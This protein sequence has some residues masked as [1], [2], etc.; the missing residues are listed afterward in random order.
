M[1]ASS[2]AERTNT[3]A[4]GQ[5]AERETAIF[6]LIEKKSLG[7][8]S[9]LGVWRSLFIDFSSSNI[10]EKGLVVFRPS[11]SSF[12]LETGFR[13]FLCTVRQIKNGLLP[14]RHTQEMG[15]VLTL[16]PWGETDGGRQTCGASTL[17]F[18][19]PPPLLPYM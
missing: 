13:S 8:H 18:F 10:R 17:Y 2:I 4:D 14:K 6:N 3:N 16:V 12:V 1:D 11:Y 15:V 9:N 5:T 19:P 7:S